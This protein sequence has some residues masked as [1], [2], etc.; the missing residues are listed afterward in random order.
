MTESNSSNSLLIPIKAGPYSGFGSGWKSSGFSFDSKAG[1]TTPFNPEDQAAGVK[2]SKESKAA[3][4]R[5]TEC[6]PVREATTKLMA[7]QAELTEANEALK[8]ATKEEEKLT[9]EFVKAEKEHDKANDSYK[10]K[11]AELIAKE[12]FDACSQQK[13]A[14]SEMTAKFNFAKTG[15]SDRKSVLQQ[16]I[17]DAKEAVIEAKEKIEDQKKVVEIAQ[18]EFDRKMQEATAFDAVTVKKEK[19]DEAEATGPADR[20]TSPNWIVTSSDPDED[21]RMSVDAN[22]DGMTEANVDSASDAG[23]DSV[24]VVADKTKTSLSAIKRTNTCRK[25]K[26]VFIKDFID[27]VWDDLS[28][29]RR[30]AVQVRFNSLVSL[31]EDQIKMQTNVSCETWSN[32]CEDVLA[33]V[34]APIDVFKQADTNF[35]NKLARK[36]GQGTRT[37][38]AVSSLGKRKAN[39]KAVTIASDVI[40]AGEEDAGAGAAK[41]VTIAGAGVAKAVTNAGAD[42]ADVCVPYADVKD[43]LEEWDFLKNPEKKPPR[44]FCQACSAERPTVWNSIKWIWSCPNHECPNK[45]HNREKKA[46]TEEILKID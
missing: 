30:E 14:M 16:N 28:T 39:A 38:A 22:V 3:H 43:N 25:N 17:Q 8:K 33:E 36:G 11:L 18:A 9:T 7:L 23:K 41:A 40:I 32:A 37:V 46:R 44:T 34:R 5:F 4:F 31:L 2:P 10:R 29:E 27:E 21:D 24:T 20:L 12:D 35:R 13:N 19:S 26:A 6:A 42:A 15:Y 1:V 45:Q